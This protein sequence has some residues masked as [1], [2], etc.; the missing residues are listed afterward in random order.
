MLTKILSERKFWLF[1]A[2][3]WTL[4]ILVLCLVS[5]NEL[6]KVGLKEADKYGHIA[7][8]FVFTLL[9]FQYFK[10]TLQKPLL[11]VFLGSLFYGG[12]IEILQGTLTATR[13]ADLHDIAA[14]TFG[15]IL[16]VLVIL[17]GRKYRK[18]K[19]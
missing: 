10:A 2:V 14:N 18:N 1:I 17:L 19:A 3:L 9:W 4:T 5:F 16:A 7:F 15:A 12:L 11:K 8:H 6:P 13:K